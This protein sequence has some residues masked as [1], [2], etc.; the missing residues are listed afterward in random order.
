MAGTSGFINKMNITVSSIRCSLQVALLG[1]V[2]PN[3]R[4]VSVTTFQNEVTLYFYY[5]H[6]PCDEEIEI[7][8]VVASEVVSDF[9][10]VSIIV[11]RIVLQM[12][13]NITEK[14]ILVFHKR[15]VSVL[16]ENV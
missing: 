4:A 6:Q 2:T 11:K 9:I 5:E 16:P 8:E 15:E 13:K 7:S 1:A 3:L 10:E 14:G 12:P